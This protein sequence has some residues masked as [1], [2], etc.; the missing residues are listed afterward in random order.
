MS[1]FRTYFVNKVCDEAFQATALRVD[2]EQLTYKYDSLVEATRHVNY[3]YQCKLCGR[4]DDVDDDFVW[5]KCIPCDDGRY[6]CHGCSFKLK[7]CTSRSCHGRVICCECYKDPDK[8][9]S[10]KCVNHARCTTFV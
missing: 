8:R 9:K 2:N 5:A 6:V 4:W 7:E 1:N 10:V 3:I